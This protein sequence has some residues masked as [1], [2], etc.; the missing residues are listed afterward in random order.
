M[1]SN[2]EQKKNNPSQTAIHLGK[3]CRSVLFS[4]THTLQFSTFLMIYSKNML[5]LRACI[6]V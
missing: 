1:G 4:L 5:H 6:Y 2:K 3:C